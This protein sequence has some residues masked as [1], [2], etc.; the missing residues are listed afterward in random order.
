LNEDRRDTRQLQDR[1]ARPHSGNSIGE[2][3]FGKVRLG[4]HTLTNERVA[5]KT[6]QKDKIVE[7]SDIERVTR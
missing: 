2:G 3:T 6:L 5:V 4:V 1:Y 7:Q